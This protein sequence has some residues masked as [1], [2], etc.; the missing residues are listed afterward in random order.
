MDITQ[1]SHQSEGWRSHFQTA[2]KSVTCSS[3]LQCCALASFNKDRGRSSNSPNS[4]QIWFYLFVLGLAFAPLSVTTRVYTEKNG[5]RC[6]S[7]PRLH[8]VFP[9]FCPLFLLFPLSS[10]PMC[11]EAWVMKSSLSVWPAHLSL[12]PLVQ[13]LCLSMLIWPTNSV[14]VWQTRALLNSGQTASSPSPLAACLPLCVLPPCLWSSLHIS[15]SFNSDSPTPI[16]SRKSRQGSPVTFFP[17]SKQK[18][19]A[20]AQGPAVVFV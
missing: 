17:V 11:R 1:G 7:A 2:I 9:L 13:P 14:Q 18:H 12:L 20:F 6:Q 3:T 8:F 19:L 10:I 5:M 4:L 16:H 15:V